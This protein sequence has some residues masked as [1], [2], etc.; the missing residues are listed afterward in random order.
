MQFLKS[1]WRRLVSS[2]WQ[3]MCYLPGLWQ[4]VG[5]QGP[6]SS[7]SQEL[8]HD[9]EDLHKYPRAMEAAERQQCLRQAEEAHPHSPSRQ[10]AEQKRNASPGNEVHQLPGEGLGGAKPTANWSGCPWK[11]SGPLPSRTPPARQDSPWWLTGSI[12]WP[13]PPPSIVGLWLSL[14]W[15]LVQKSLAVN[16]D[17]HIPQLTWW[18]MCEARIYVS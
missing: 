16:S 8:Q 1:G 6:F 11:H 4:G 7:L 15:A 2:C 14:P 9:R 18:I 3:D 13:K 5:A 12:A 17:L 10:E